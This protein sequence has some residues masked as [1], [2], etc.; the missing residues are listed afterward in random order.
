MT[1][2]TPTTTDRISTGI[3]GL[4]QRALSVMKKRSGQHESTIRELRIGPGRLHVGRALSEFQGVLTGVP[5]YIGAAEGL[6]DGRT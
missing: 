2:P 6:R 1:P 4:D 3:A 5:Q